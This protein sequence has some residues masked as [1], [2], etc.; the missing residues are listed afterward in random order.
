MAGVLGMFYVAGWGAVLV[1][2]LAGVVLLVANGTGDL[3]QPGGWGLGLVCVC[4]GAGGC[5]GLLY[6]G[7]E[8]TL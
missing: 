7:L 4:V 3:K 2:E 1:V 5:A 8:Q 6:H